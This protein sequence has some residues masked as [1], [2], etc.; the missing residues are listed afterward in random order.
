[1]RELGVV[2]RVEGGKGVVQLASRGGCKHCGVNAY[3]NSTGASKRELE[4]GLGGRR[5]EPG[6]WVE[7]ETPARSLLTAAFLVFILPLMVSVAAYAVV[8]SLTGS[9]GLGLAGF[10]VFF[11]LSEV[12]V[13][14]VDR[15]FGRRQ[16][17]E[18]RIVR[19]VERRLEAMG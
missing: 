14:G 10:F 13:A 11:I 12:M 16:F 6:D 15:I 19:K 17:F 1:M 8:S 9:Q 2:V 4:L 3:C 7:I 5:C 18:P